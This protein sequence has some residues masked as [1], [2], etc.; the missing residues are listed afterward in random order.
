MSSGSH[1]IRL[2]IFDWAGTTVDFGSRAPAAAFQNV[3]ARH[4]VDVTDAEAR[5]PMGLNKREHLMAMLSSPAIAA[6]WDA[7]HGRA[8]SEADVDTMYDE[9]VPLQLEAIEE[10]AELVPGLLEVVSQLRARDL[11]I[12]GTTGYFR[13][14]AQTVAA[15]AAAAGFAPDA[16]VCSDDVPRGRPAPWM[17]YRIM[18]R[19]EIWPPAA[20]VKVGD[21]IAD[22]EA[23]LAAGCWSVGVCD[24]SSLMGLSEA[25]YNALSEDERSTRLAQ[26][27]DLFREAG[28]H[29]VLCSLSELPVLIDEINRANLPYP[30]RLSS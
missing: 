19:L 11:R 8:W 4:S 29:A 28:A 3:F 17:I 10:H 30:Q 13:A 9:F 24:S 15:R 16:N 26:T 7:V 22:I 6:R 23:G 21:T 14:A 1:A 18:E 25:E 2:M 27:A 12:G 5:G 20:V